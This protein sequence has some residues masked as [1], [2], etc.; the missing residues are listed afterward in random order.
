[1][2]KYYQFIIALCCLLM[3]GCLKSL[4]EEGITDGIQ[5]KGC[6]EEKTS[7]IAIPGVSVAITNGQRDGEK[8]R[9][10]SDGSFSLTISFEQLNE[11]YYLFLTA[12]SLYRSTTVQFPIIGYGLKEYDLQ[13]IAMDGPELP[14]VQTDAVSGILQT[15]AIGGGSVTDD[16][17]SSI[18]R[19]GICWGTAANPTIVNNHINAGNGCGHFTAPIE[20]LVAGKT[21]HVRAYAENGV[22]I[23]YG[24]DVTFTTRSGIPV[25]ST[26]AVSD[27]TQHSVTC[28]GTVTNDN[29]HTVTARGLCYS[30]T[31]IEPTLNDSYTLDGTGTG[32]F[33]TIITGMQ[34]GTTYYL[35]AY[36]TNAIGTGYGEVKT[37]TTF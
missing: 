21:Y 30:T 7:G 27:I 10:Y 16:G 25:V 32:S 35:R 24:Q 20:G 29:G 6:V 12:D 17:R 22:G 33:S 5:V 34:S 8:T 19:R 11:G 1:M 15:S 26:A 2:K 28:G 3:V 18:R 37:V 23:V 36:A 13:T 9:T 4:D 31:S 14:T